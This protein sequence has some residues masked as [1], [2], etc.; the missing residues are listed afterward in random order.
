MQE[1]GRDAKSL[2]EVSRMMVAIEHSTQGGTVE[3]C[4]VGESER[5][6]ARNP[7]YMGTGVASFF[8]FTHCQYLKAHTGIGL[9]TTFLL[10]DTF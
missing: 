7:V 10:K 8:H 2:Q 3:Y 5:E 4:W 6:N 9:E 1:V